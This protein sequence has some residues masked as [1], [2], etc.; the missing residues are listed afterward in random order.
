[1][2][3]GYTMIHKI[4][5]CTNFLL[6]MMDRFDEWHRQGHSMRHKRQLQQ[7]DL[8]LLT[9]LTLLMEHLP[10]EREKLNRKEVNYMRNIHLE[11]LQ[12]VMS[13]QTSKN[14]DSSIMSIVNT[15]KFGRRIVFSA[16]LIEKIGAEREI[17]ISMN[18][19][20]IA[21]G[22]D[23]PGN[24]NTFRLK[25]Y[26]RKYVLYATELI[27]EIT[28][29]F[30]LDFTGRTTI[31]FYEVVY[32]EHEPPIAFIKMTDEP[33]DEDDVEDSEASPLDQ[34]TEEADESE[35]SDHE[36]IGDDSTINDV[37]ERE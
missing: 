20:G 4:V 36:E 24:K 9:P 25:D 37:K 16:K 2:M 31:S 5:D 7:L 22:T 35:Y 28:D 18:D 15:N 23:L 14:V 11:S 6:V 34:E 8:T 3:S 10:H 32:I 19:E 26:G 29:F 13:K 21:I 12:P 27:H 17:Q 30:Q 1:M 33:V